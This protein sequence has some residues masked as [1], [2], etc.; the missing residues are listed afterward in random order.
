MQEF[1]ADVVAKAMDAFSPLPLALFFCASV[2]LLIFMRRLGL[3]RR[4]HS[5]H[6]FLVSL[7]HLY[8]PAV[9]LTLGF[10]WAMIGTFEQAFISACTQS[11]KSI[12]ENSL[13]K[14][15][16]VMA[17]TSR[18]FPGNAPLSLKDLSQAIT[19]SYIRQY[20]EKTDLDPLPDYVRVLL[21]PLVT[22]M[23]TAFAQRL[24]AHV[25]ERLIREA[26][27]SARLT[28][29]AVDDL[30]KTDIV[31]AMRDSLAVS[32]LRAQIRDFFPPYYQ[33]VKFLLVLSLLPIAAETGLSFL[34]LGILRRFRA[35]REEKKA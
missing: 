26:A 12:R 23:Q 28:P 13:E 32:V 5:L 21:V 17:E 6:A 34:I 22:P 2:I 7:Y 10:T 8:L 29:A 25:E 33:N 30:F 3:L 27:A 19:L 1:W 14:T 24:A 20:Q 4:P 11:E 16:M 15:F 18:R 35:R 9:F 31:P